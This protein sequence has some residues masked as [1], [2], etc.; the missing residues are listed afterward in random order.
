MVPALIVLTLAWAVGAIMTDVGADRLFERWI[1][2]SGLNAGSLP[3][4]TFLIAAL[5]AISTG[6]SWGKMQLF[7]LICL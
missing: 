6:T 4:I 3:T 1:V 5:L 7:L 2:D